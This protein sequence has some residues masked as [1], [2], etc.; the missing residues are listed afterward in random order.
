M[1]RNNRYLLVFGGIMILLNTVL[2]FLVISSKSIS[3][4][5]VL[6]K[7]GVIEN[8]NHR[9]S[10]TGRIQ[11]KLVN[12]SFTSFH[13]AIT[14]NGEIIDSAYCGKF[15]SAYILIISGNMC[16]TC[17]PVALKI[18]SNLSARIGADRFFIFSNYSDP[19]GLFLLMEQNGLNRKLGIYSETLAMHYG[20]AEEIPIL[21]KLNSQLKVEKA[22]FVDKHMPIKFYENFI[23]SK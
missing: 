15:T 2:I 21:I 9:I 5:E 22:C 7:D 23:N 10:E 6:N 13:H 4:K 17:I 19:A 8:L 20:G 14:G 1:L 18:C 3:Q 16:P 12:L 11:S